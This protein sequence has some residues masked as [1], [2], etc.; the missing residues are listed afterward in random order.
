[1]GKIRPYKRGVASSEGDTTWPLVKRGKHLKNS[2]I[3]IYQIQEMVA[4]GERMEACIFISQMVR[5]TKASLIK[6][7]G[8]TSYI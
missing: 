7:G 3:I 1:V 6:E 4:L 8:Y 5:G 2:S